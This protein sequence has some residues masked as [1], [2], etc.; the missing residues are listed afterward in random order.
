MP[1]TSIGSAKIIQQFSPAGTYTHYTD[2]E[3][4]EAQKGK[5]LGCLIAAGCWSWESVHGFLLALTGQ[6]MEV[7]SGDVQH[8]VG[9]EDLM[10]LQSSGSNRGL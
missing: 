7:P 6:V 3:T 10:A 9:T 4:K 8:L 2:V 5:V 1:F